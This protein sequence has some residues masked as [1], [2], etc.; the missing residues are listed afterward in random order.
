MSGTPAS[1]SSNYRQPGLCY[2]IAK[3]LYFRGGTS[4]GAGRADAPMQIVYAMGE[5]YI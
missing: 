2:V 1:I 5:D 3:V 4:Y